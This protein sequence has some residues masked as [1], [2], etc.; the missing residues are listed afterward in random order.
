MQNVRWMP[1]TYRLRLTDQLGNRFAVVDDGRGAAI[2]VL[3][4]RV[5]GIDA[6]VMVDRGQEIARAAA[7]VD[8]VFASFVRRA[9]ESTGLDAATGPQVREGAWPMVSSRLLGAGGG[10]RVANA[11][12]R[13]II[14]Q[15]RATEFAGDHRPALA[16]PSRVRRCLRSALIPPGHKLPRGIASRRRRDD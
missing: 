10:T 7:T 8:G 15:R 16:C 9:D 5:R 12:A 11:R 1:K 4:Q 6:Q 2:E 13:L 3:D 14:D